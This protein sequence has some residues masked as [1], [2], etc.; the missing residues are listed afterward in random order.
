MESQHTLEHS[1]RSTQASE[2]EGVEVLSTET[3]SIVS[4]D[5]IYSC[6]EEDD[7]IREL[8]GEE[9]SVKD[10]WNQLGCH[11]LYFKRFVSSK[12]YKQLNEIIHAYEAKGYGLE[13]A[14]LATLRKRKYLIQKI[15]RE[16]NEKSDGT[17][18]Q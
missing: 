7:P 16:E 3:R 11:I 9:E 4:N 8:A 12:M 17:D 13:E 14:I 10:F 1:E 6:V 5:D 15:F 18:V 2:S